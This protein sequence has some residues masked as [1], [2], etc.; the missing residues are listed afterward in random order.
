MH[1]KGKT[2]PGIRA[3]YGNRVIRIGAVRIVYGIG[4]EGAEV[5]AIFGGRRW[6]G[7]PCGN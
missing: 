1:V 2:A 4:T 6:D 7:L 3:F 5:R